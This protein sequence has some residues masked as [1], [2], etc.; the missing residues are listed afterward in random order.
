[1]VDPILL[2]VVRTKL[3][4]ISD[5]A[6]RT[7]VRTAISPVVAEAGDCSCSI[8]APNGDLLS[9]GGPIVMHQHTGKNGITKILEMHGDE[10]AEGDIFLVN[11]PYAG[12]G[13]HAQDVFVH[14]PI[15]VE[16]QLIAW[17]GASAH[18]ID[19]GGAVF[20]SFVTTATECYQE[21][22]RFPPVRISRRGEEQSDIWSM[23]RNNVRLA[24]L[25]ELDIRALI[26]ATHVCRER[27]LD[28][29]GQYGTA[30]IREATAELLDRTED[31]MRRRIG[32]L[33]PGVYSSVS[34]SEW[35]EEH[36]KVPC[37]LTVEADALVFDFTEASDQTFHFINSKPFV[38]TSMVGVQ[39]AN[40]VGHDLPLNEGLFRT[41]EVRCRPGSILDAQPPA[42]IGAPH[43][44]VGMTASEVAMYALNLAIAAS[45][46]SQVRK[47]M[48]G[49]SAGSCMALHILAGTG[50][51]GGPDGFMLL[52]SGYV[53]TSAANDRD[54]ADTYF[55]G[56]GRFASVETTDIEVLESW[57]PML[58]E[59]RR[60]RPGTGGAGK[61]R[62]GAGFSMGYQID[63]SQDMAITLLGNRERVPI[64][65]M[66]GGIPGAMTEYHIRRTDGSVDPLACH[67]Q[68]VPIREGESL[69]F[70]LASGGGWGDPMDRD[71]ERVEADVKA[72]RLTVAEARATY[73]V[74]VGDLEA[75]A[76]ARSQ[77]LTERLRRAEPAKIPLSWT[78]E[79]R[80]AA[81]AEAP[82]PLYLGVVQQA[83][84][85]VSER[86]GEPL[87]VSPHSWTDGCPVIRNF[88][89]AGPQTDIVAYLDPGSGNLLAV[90]VV[91]EGTERSF[92]TEPR[93]WTEAAS[94]PVAV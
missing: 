80:E 7:I 55:E 28:L 9:G 19:M 62:A 77:A 61:F 50:L 3:N 10:V 72:G 51:H 16:G 60:P 29:V 31:A 23:I 17:A 71:P 75:T 48:S 85:A 5:E 64:A 36:F 44:D 94:A 90:D 49:P 93:R 37:T 25:I 45:P 52:E 56:V 89:P 15:F 22:L 53:G 69:L 27:I 12:G 66:S 18:M 57:Y 41:F 46:H 24:D 40:I 79:L 1:M 20:G 73:G 54:P 82:R 32:E 63:G 87:A 70:D 58:V 42:P 33:E 43:L 47:N 81:E 68:G 35:T 39:L 8:Y 14:R 6:A 76:E 4:A 2:E 88:L 11:D 67:Q 78:P 38:I 26:S 84:V 91:L 21:A 59:Y 83:S 34:W 74:V 65:G 30:T 13:V 92:T 86:T